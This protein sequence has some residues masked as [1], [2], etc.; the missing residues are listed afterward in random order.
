M[1]AKKLKFFA[2]ILGLHP[3]KLRMQQAK[4]ALLGEE[5]VPASSF[6]LSSLKQL[7]P[8]V[9]PWL[10][11]GMPYKKRSVLISNLYNHTPTPME[12]GWSVKKTQ[13]KDFRGKNLTYNSHNAVDFSIPVGTKVCAAAPGK[14]IQVQSEFNRGGL[15]IHI[16][17]GKGLISGYVH[18]AR[19]FVK[20]G[21]VVKRG[22]V[23]ALSGYSGLDGLS[24][25][26]FGIP[27]VHF[28]TW[29][30][31]KPVEAF[32]YG[33]HISLW[34]A[35]NLPESHNANATE[36][37][38]TPSTYDAQ[39]L[40]EAIQLCKTK[41]SRDRLL[42]IK[43]PYYQAAELLLEMNYYPTR[44]EKHIHIYPE[45][46]PRIAHLDLPF[47]SEDFDQVVFLDEV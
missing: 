15:K 44:F 5:D 11:M 3:F 8:M 31:G 1:K 35:G 43:D 9:S 30:N 12:A 16:D 14:V 45:V 34:K 36:E 39:K 7:H 29:L 10:W 26:P 4:I 13:T 20:L 28:N 17:H 23:I 41:R 25:F 37:A 32:A 21:Q 6:G 40:A 47:S 42:A 33:E 2:E 24:T 27:H 18:L 38:F 22:E 46:F 19:S